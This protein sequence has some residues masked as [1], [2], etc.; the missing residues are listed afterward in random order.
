MTEPV[1]IRC[2]HSETWPIENFKEHP[3][4]PNR[5]PPEQLDM[6]ADVIR[7]AGWRSP[8]VVSKRSGFVIKGHGRLL[9]A[10]IAGLSSA[11][12]EVQDYDSEDAEIADMIA[13]NRISE[14]SE[15]DEFML[16]ETL[17]ELP[18]EWRVKTGFTEDEFAAI[19]AAAPAPTV[20]PLT[21]K[22]KRALPK[23]PQIRFSKYIILMTPEESD[24]I[25]ALAE[26]YR[27]QSGTLFGFI[28]HLLKL[29]E[30]PK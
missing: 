13:D 20:P 2:L 14:L 24:G 28:R 10:K 25:E 4:N 17:R 9:A 3:R 29:A 1:P 21:A 26:A 22:E 18:P 27:E 6:L 8:I 19:C 5:H 23:E 30:A 15:M 16:S 11:P 12:V 7:A